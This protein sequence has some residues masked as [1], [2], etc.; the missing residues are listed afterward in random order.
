MFK[1]KLFL[2]VALLSAVALLFGACEEGITTPS[3]PTSEPSTTITTETAEEEAN[4]RLLVSDEIN[5]IG[6]FEHLYVTVTSIGVQQ[7]GESGG[8][9][10]FSPEIDEV[11][12]TELIGDNAV[13]IW[14]GNLTP[15]T[16][17]KVFIYVSEV[18]GV[19]VGENKTVEVKLPSSKLQISKPFTVTE[20]SVTSFVYDLTVVAAGNEKSGIKYILKPQIAQSGAEQEFKE[21]KQERER[22]REREL[23]LQI[24]GEALPGATVM[25]IVSTD[26]GPA[27]GAEVTI[28]DEDAGTTDADGRLEITIP[29]DVEEVEIKAR[30]GEMEGE[31][32][33]EFEEEAE[34]IEFEGTI[35]DL[36]DNITWTMTADNETKLVDVSTADI[37]GVPAVGL[38]AEVDGIVVDGIVVATK[39]EVEDGEQEQEQAQE[40]EGEE[41][42]FEGT[43]DDL[44]D[45]ITWTMTADNETKLVDVST[46]DIE[47]EPA[48]GLVA[49][50]EGVVIDGVVVAR[51]IEV[52]EAEEE[53]V[54]E[55]VEI[56]CDDFIEEQHLSEEV[57]LAVGDVLEIILCSNPTTGFEWE[58]A[59]ISDEN[60][61]EQLTHDYIPPQG[62]Q[63]GAAGEEVWTFEALEADTVEVS[64]EY[65][66]PWDGGNKDEWTFILTVEIE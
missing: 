23:Q 18:N 38:M 5:A 9:T 21:V 40:Q 65:S 64:F 47:G 54:A 44:G 2:V 62:N 20:D 34:E 16:Y 39:V 12:L 45:N 13:E 33:L 3:E 32:E 35:D 17:N 66:Q 57:E 42:E 11:D 36:G 53:S 52:K 59:N 29:E 51:E 10:Q 24:E 55:T 14:S 50:V 26:Q 37:E 56:D 43:I 25:L 41:I 27:E 61:L 30:L 8:W 19:L 49:E 7:G 28:D 15:G 6:H 46:A 48:V 4:F 60:I 63:A 1:S 58:T 31:L 22:E